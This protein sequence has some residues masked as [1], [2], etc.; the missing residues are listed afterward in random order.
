MHTREEP[1]IDFAIIGAQKSGTTALFDMLNQHPEIQFGYKKEDNY[2]VQEEI[3]QS[4]PAHLYGIYATDKLNGLRG[5]AYVNLMY[6][7]SIA[8]PRL[9]KNNPSMKIVAILRDPIDRAYSAFHYMRSRMMEPHETFEAAI[10]QELVSLDDSFQFQANRTYLGHGHYAS[11]LKPFLDAFGRENVRIYDQ[12]ELKRSYQ[13]V[14]SDAFQFL[15]VQDLAGTVTQSLSNQTGM[16]A[17]SLIPRLIYSTGS[18]KSLYV[19]LLPAAARRRL[20]VGVVRKVREAN[21]KQVQFPPMSSDTRARLA[22]YYAPHNEALAQL[23]GR[24]SS[25]WPAPFSIK[26]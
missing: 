25:L 26:D 14:C 22:A 23:L 20:R 19:R 8:V 3:Y 13:E 10:E 9:Y 24:E 18:L 16:P 12:A 17:V 6:F 2:F 4:G 1:K 21:L 5:Y 11:Q 7:H 15:G